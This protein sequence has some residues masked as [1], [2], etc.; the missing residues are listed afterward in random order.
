MTK[1]HS[2]WVTF[3]GV[4]LFIAGVL[5]VVYGIAAIGDSKFYLDSGTY[6]I[7]DLHVYGWVV[8]LIGVVQAAAVFGI[9]TRTTWARWVGIAT[10][11]VNAI[12]QVLWIATYPFAA[13]AILTLDILVI[14]GLVAHGRRRA[15]V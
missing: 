4:M 12:V 13:V 10:A 11:A 6:V 8:L 15:S 14:Y 5:N 3:A 9:F 7:R 2:G 1:T